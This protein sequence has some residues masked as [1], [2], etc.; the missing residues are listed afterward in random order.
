MQYIL[1]YFIFGQFA[2][3]HLY[4]ACFCCSMLSCSIYIKQKTLM[5]TFICL[6]SCVFGGLIEYHFVNQGHPNIDSHQSVSKKWSTLDFKF[7]SLPIVDQTGLTAYIETTQNKKMILKA[8]TP[9]KQPI[10]SAKF[11]FTHKCQMQGKIKAA[12]KIGQTDFFNVQTIQHKSCYPTTPLWRDYIHFFKNLYTERMLSSNLIGKD[13]I[14]ALTTGNTQYIHPKELSLIRQLGISHLFA[15]SGTH[16]GILLSLLYLIL[17]RLPIPI[18]LIKGIVVCLLPIYL[19]FAGASPSAQRAVLMACIAIIF[20]KVILSNGITVLSLAYVVLSIYSPELHYHLGFQFS[21]AICFFLILSQKWFSKKSLYMLLWQTTLV[22]FYGTLAISYHHFNEIQWQ[23]IITN[24]LFI[25]LY[26]FMIIPFALLTIP[27]YLLTPSVIDSISFLPNCLFY[28]QDKLL[29]ISQPLAK[30]HWIIA[31]YG[32]I[33]FLI[34]SICSFMS[35][36]LLNLKK[37][38]H[39]LIFTVLIIFYTIVFK[40]PQINEMTLIDVGQGDAILFKTRSQKTLLI[41]TGGQPPHMQYRSHF[42]ITERKL[43]PTLKAKGI[44]H[45]DYLLITHDDADHMGELKQLADRVD[46]HNIIINPQHFN[47]NLLREVIEVTKSENAVLHSAF[48]M[49]ELRLDDFKFHFLNATL[50]QSENPNDHSIITLARLND[51]HVLLMGDA[52]VA[53]ENLLRKNFLL[54]K[55]NILKV[56]H[57]GS[58]TSTSETFLAFI[59]PEIALIS[60]GKNNLY[61][62]P[63]PEIIERLRKHQ[64]TTYNTADNQNITIQFT[65]GTYKI[66]KSP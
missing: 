38:L 55:I 27:L 13:K 8:Y 9:P 63:H 16:V 66:I 51:I 41:D 39:H 35:L 52:T 58:N 32:E 22:S 1:C 31:N 5:F 62:L 65:Q 61:R 14:I 4:T 30:F 10:P 17:K 21:F 29:Q 6:L 49:K 23:S 37:Y 40:P 20:S 28:L 44:T 24:M 15:V 56:G 53:N 60:S 25:P 3:H 11:Y 12:N 2:V 47:S 50:K 42:N 64:V 46:I 26:T 18:I 7:I 19:I 34:I 59:Q 43:Y 36:L 48:E 54:P 45:I 33:G 57:H